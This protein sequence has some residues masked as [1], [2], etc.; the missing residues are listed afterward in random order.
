ME[1]PESRNH[2]TVVVLIV[3]TLWSQLRVDHVPRQTEKRKTPVSNGIS[4]SE[5]QVNLQHTQPWFLSESRRQSPTPSCQ[6]TSQ[7]SNPRDLVR[8][9]TF[10]KKLVV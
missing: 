1:A 8:L 9:M 2:P 7:V 10:E 3:L 4:P 5:P 6:N